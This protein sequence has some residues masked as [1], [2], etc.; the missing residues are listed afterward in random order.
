MTEKKMHI[1]VRPG[2]DTGSRAARVIRKMALKATGQ[3]TTV[4][5][6]ARLSPPP[7]LGPEMAAPVETEAPAIAP[8]AAEGE[9]PFGQTIRIHEALRVWSRVVGEL[10]DQKKPDPDTWVCI[11]SKPDARSVVFSTSIGGMTVGFQDTRQTMPKFKL[12]CRW[13]PLSKVLL[14]PE[15]TEIAVVGNALSYLVNGQRHEIA[16]DQKVKS[17]QTIVDVPLSG[18][19]KIDGL[20]LAIQEA[21]PFCE[22]DI[23]ENGLHQIHITS[24]KRDSPVCLVIGASTRGIYRRTLRAVNISSDRYMHIK[25]AVAAVLTPDLQLLASKSRTWLLTETGLLFGLDNTDDILDT[26]NLDEFLAARPQRVDWV[27]DECA[28]LRRAV[29]QARL[30]PMAFRTLEALGITPT[31]SGL[32]IRGQEGKL[33]VSCS[34]KDGPEILID[35]A[36]LANAIAI[37]GITGFDFDPEDVQSKPIRFSGPQVAVAVMPL[38]AVTV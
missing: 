24:T 26:L 17:S 29:A 5:N 8:A 11:H 10:L 37:R 3:P 12:Y 20:G 7:L 38:R 21:L 18:Y 2:D 14:R 15:V 23:S 16:V 6:M 27:F 32:Q 35:Q 34:S 31:G 1:T 13:E 33:S 28:A 19:S 22:E 9:V 30:H 4:I 36:L 25:P